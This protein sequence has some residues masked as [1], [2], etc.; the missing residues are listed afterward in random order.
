MKVQKL[1]LVLGIN[2]VAACMVM[3]GCKATK[4]GRDVP[5]PASETDGVITVIS[6][7]EQKPVA[8]PAEPADVPEQPITSEG[9]VSTPAPKTVAPPP[10][11]PPS[12]V[13]KVKP[14]PP[15]PHAAKPTPAKPAKSSVATVKPL[16]PKPAKSAAAAKTAAPAAAS[17]EYVVKPGDSLFLISKRTNYK[18][19]AILAANPGLNADRIRIGQKIKLP[20]AAPVA[21]AAAVAAAPAD[22]KDAGKKA[23]TV[24]KADGKK[25]DAKVMAASAAAP[26]PDAAAANT[27]APV[28]TKSAFAAYE[29]PTKEYTVV[30]G[31]SLGKIALE[32]G[33]SIRALKKLN[34]LTKDN[35]RVGQ[36]LKIPA[37]K[38]I[39]A[40]KTAVVPPAPKAA[41]DEKKAAVGEKKAAASAKTAVETKD[42]KKKDAAAEQKPAVDAKDAKKPAEAAKPAETAKPT[43]VAK[44]A[45]PSPVADE[46][47]AEAV[48][49]AEPAP[50]AAEAAPATGLTYTVKEGDDLVSIAIAYGISPS[51]LMDANDLK[52]T[53]EVKPGQVLKLPANAKVGGAQ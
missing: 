14:L 7:P 29:G 20:G 32:S 52:V 3:Q 39:A 10:P 19:S 36:K 5:P 47:P 24:A 17:E 41:A 22:A 46:K 21:A 13:A 34:G 33:I 51:A 37:E 6:R 12:S 38:Q 16:P 25:A 28:K 49:P 9:V 45:E 27:K 1:G 50:V 40:P 44:P 26:T 11:P 31:D 35:L 4:S 15:T 53:D 8:G 42:A 30:S 18:Q 48:K 23:E 43:E 2:M